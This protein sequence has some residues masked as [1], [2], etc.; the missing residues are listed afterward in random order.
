MIKDNVLNLI[1]I[2]I[3]PAVRNSEKDKTK[4][5]ETMV[6]KGNHLEGFMQDDDLGNFHNLQVNLFARNR[7]QTDFISRENTWE[8]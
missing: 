6:R 8:K 1:I 4:D 7:L 3:E 2:A 5:P